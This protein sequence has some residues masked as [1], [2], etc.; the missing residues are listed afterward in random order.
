MLL[1][2]GECFF[3]TSVT[4]FASDFMTA[5]GYCVVLYFVNSN[6]DLRSVILA[7]VL[8]RPNVTKQQPQLLDGN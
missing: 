8:Q 1:C 2:M 3:R 4:S 5:V 6:V 7:S